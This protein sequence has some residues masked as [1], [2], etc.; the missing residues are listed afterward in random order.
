M[1]DVWL[2]ATYVYPNLYE[3]YVPSN[4]GESLFVSTYI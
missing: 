1:K 4:V 2:R 3:I